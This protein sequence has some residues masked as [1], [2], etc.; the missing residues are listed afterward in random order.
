MSISTRWNTVRYVAKERLRFWFSEATPRIF[1]LAEKLKN[2][3]NSRSVGSNTAL[4]VEGYPRCG[5]SFAFSTILKRSDPPLN[6]AHHI[7][8]PVQVKAGV[9]LSLPVLVLVREPKDAIGS[10]VA[11]Q[12]QAGRLEGKFQDLSDADLIFR[13]REAARYYAR[14]YE[15][16]IE[17]KQGFLLAPFELVV[18]DFSKV[19]E[20]LNT[21][22]GFSFNSI[23]ISEREKK[24]VFSVGGYHLSPNE[25]RNNHKARI[26][27]LYPDAVSQTLQQRTRNIYQ[28]LLEHPAMIRG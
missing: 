6:I 23:P 7:H 28:M 20:T 12:L 22:Y 1:L 11:L 4:I 10:F 9:E 5:N 25:E 8:L 16:I 3:A 24:Q 14:F 18:R 19:L 26:A 13:I 15:R 2:G 27:A 17:I 21:C